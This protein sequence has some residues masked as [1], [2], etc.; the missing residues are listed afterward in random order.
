MGGQG[1]VISC[2]LAFGE[3]IRG[4]IVDEYNR[5][6]EEKENAETRLRE[7]RYLKD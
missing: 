1:L 3:I 7:C 2:R 6:E 5:V 4:G